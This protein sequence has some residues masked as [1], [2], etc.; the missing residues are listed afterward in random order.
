MGDSNQK[1]IELLQ[2][3]IK[4]NN[5]KLAE[6]V[7]EVAFESK[8]Q[9]DWVKNVLLDSAGWEYENARF[10]A[11]LCEKIKGIK[12]KGGKVETIGFSCQELDS[13]FFFISTYKGVGG[14]EAAMFTQVMQVIEPVYG[15]FRTMFDENTNLYRQLQDL[16]EEPEE[17]TGEDIV[18]DGG[19]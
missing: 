16:T 17:E 19:E 7:F 9:F 14:V 5:E 6:K 18:C 12:I 4:S 15:T 11:A 13:L 8:E 3:T 2:E 10:L 1:Q